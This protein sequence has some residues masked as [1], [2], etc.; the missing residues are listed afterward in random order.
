LQNITRE[1]ISYSRR[2]VRKHKS[3][4]NLNKSASQ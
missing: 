2:P 4:L 1:L 3:N